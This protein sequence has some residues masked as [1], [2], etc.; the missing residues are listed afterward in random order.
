MAKGRTVVGDVPQLLLTEV[1]VAFQTIPVF[2]VWDAMVINE[3]SESAK[4]FELSDTHV[5]A[6]NSLADLRV[7]LPTCVLG[8]SF[9]KPVSVTKR[10]VLVVKRP[11]CVF[12][13]VCWVD[14]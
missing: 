5:S 10:G 12:S 8:A 7:K 2:W 6:P 14:V 9:K 1:L 13:V 4:G 3:L 11:V